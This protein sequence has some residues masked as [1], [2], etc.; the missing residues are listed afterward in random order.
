M[1]VE[2]CCEFLQRS[3]SLR[4]PST[5]ERTRTIFYARFLVQHRWQ[6]CYSNTSERLHAMSLGPRRSI[7]GVHSADS[8]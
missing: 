4:N 5:K 1:A 3:A 2:H 7:P 8:S 6:K